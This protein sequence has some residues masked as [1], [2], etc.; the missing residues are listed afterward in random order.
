MC[1]L[2][3]FPPNT[4]RQEAIEI[5]LEFEGRSNRDG[6]GCAHVDAET[7][8]FVVVKYPLSLSH[9][10]LKKMPFLDHMPHPGWTIAHLRAASHGGNTIE[11][12]HPFIVGDMC[13][14][15]NGIWSD[16]SIVRSVIGKAFDIK[17]EGQTDSEVAAQYLKLVGPEEFLQNVN[18]GGVYL[19]L[20][21]D[22]SL[23]VIKTSGNL[24]AVERPTQKNAK[25]REILIASTFSWQ[26]YKTRREAAPGWYHLSAE[27]KLL[28]RQIVRYADPYVRHW[29]DVN[30]RHRVDDVTNEDEAMF[31]REFG[32]S[33][34]NLPVVVKARRGNLYRTPYV[35]GPGVHQHQHAGFVD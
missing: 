10:L 2:A 18:M 6:V 24:E 11:N 34:Q 32:E 5:L 33:F 8:E 12:T 9:I 23:L 31:R 29:N 35:S 4:T 19:A 1:R 13:V 7:G 25:K 22:G 17:W 14:C 20:K 28:K 3:A 15:H 27:G 21:K 16:Y 26:Q 30:E